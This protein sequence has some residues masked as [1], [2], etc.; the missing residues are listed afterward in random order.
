MAASDAGAWRRK[1]LV[2]ALKRRN[3]FVSA[4]EESFPAAASTARKKRGRREGDS[5]SI[6]VA[7]LES[8]TERMRL[9]SWH[10]EAP[11]PEMRSGLDE[12]FP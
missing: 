4:T 12:A 9:P 2:K 11:L 5:D 10:T 8:N 6:V 7:V 1:G 3:G